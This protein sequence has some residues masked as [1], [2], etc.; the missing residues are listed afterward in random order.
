MILHITS[1]DN[2]EKGRVLDPGRVKHAVVT[3]KR[4]TDLSWWINPSTHLNLDL[5]DELL[6][7]VFVASR[8]EKGARIIADGNRFMYAPI[9]REAYRHLGRVDITERRRVSLRPAIHV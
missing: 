5:P 7:E 8:M 4:I 6:G 3:G 2:I 1:L 9:E